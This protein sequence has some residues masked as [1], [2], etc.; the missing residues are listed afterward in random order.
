MINLLPPAIKTEIAHSRKNAII[1]RYLMGTV[2]LGV[3]FAAM[4]WYGHHQL[5]L[6]MH[7]ANQRIAEKQADINQ[8]K[9]LETKAQVLSGRLNAIASVQKSQAKFSV[10]LDDLAQYMPSGTAVSSI[11]LT[12]DDKKPVRLTV[13]ASD[14]KTA[15]SFRDSIARSKR[16]SA[17]DIESVQ[18]NDVGLYDV[19]VTF[20]FSPG[21]AR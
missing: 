5:S 9:D 17:A 7:A 14:Y 10:L 11:T 8:H 15:L 12:G 4:F 3:A 20:T 21:G 1:I 6:Q 18:Q 16:I 13:S 2:G 19:T